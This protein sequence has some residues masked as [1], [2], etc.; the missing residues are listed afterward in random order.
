[1]TDK[2]KKKEDLKKAEDIK[3]DMDYSSYTENLKSIS[4][5]KRLAFMVLFVIAIG[6]TEAIVIVIAV[7]QFLIKIFTG[8]TNDKLEDFGSSLGIFV[9]QIYSLSPSNLM[10]DLIH[11]IKIGLSQITRIEFHSILL[12]QFFYKNMPVLKCVKKRFN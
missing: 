2:S 5:W 11:L 7:L 4:L 6:I 10:K 8:A 3:V 12:A 9:A 1:M